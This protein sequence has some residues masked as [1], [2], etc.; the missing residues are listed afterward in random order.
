MIGLD[1]PDKRRGLR[2]IIQ[3]IVVFI[4]L[5]FVWHWAAKLD[6]DG[7]REGMRWALAIVGVGT[8]G[9]VMEN[10]L[11]AFK[12]SLGKDGA[13]ISAGSGEAD[14]AQK[15]TDAAQDV[16]DELKG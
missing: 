12:L 13:T 7:L 15:A 8:I 9:Y 1:N 16:A 2:S 6:A 5:Y 14:G 3:A 4:L 10:G 11:R